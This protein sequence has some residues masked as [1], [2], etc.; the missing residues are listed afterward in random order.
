[1]VCICLSSIYAAQILLQASELMGTSVAGHKS[2]LSV[3][4]QSGTYK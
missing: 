1:M 2:T 3:F 4:A